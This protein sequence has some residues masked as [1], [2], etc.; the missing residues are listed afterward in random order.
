MDD[1]N[2]NLP[3]EQSTSQPVESNDS[4]QD[5]ATN[6]SFEPNSVSYES[7]ET[8][9]PYSEGLDSMPAEDLTSYDATD[10]TSD[11]ETD[12]TTTPE[13]VVEEQPMYDDAAPEEV[14]Y[15]STDLPDTSMEDLS[16]DPIEVPMESAAP[17]DEVSGPEAY[18]GGD[19]TNPDDILTE[20]GLQDDQGVPASTLAASDGSAL[21][22]PANGGSGNNKKIFALLALTILL[23]GVLAVTVWYFFLRDNG[24]SGPSATPTPTSIPQPT[25]A[26]DTHLECRFGLCVEVPGPGDNLC[27][28]SFDCE[29]ATITPSV[30]P[31]SNPTTIPVASGTPAE[32]SPTP[33]AIATATPEPTTALPTVVP[34]VAPTST[35]TP[36][37][38]S[39]PTPTPLAD[40]LP[41]SGTSDNTLM[42]AFLLAA[43]T[44][45][46]FLL[47][48]KKHV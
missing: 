24:T 40:S 16:T 19:S 43:S 8:T 10:A 26:S 1:Q 41:T 7:T 13:D 38:I 46:G 34:T 15:E 18:E 22:A 2:S 6:D 12:M 29:Q 4:G 27:A 25:T 37:T 32:A 23:L 11:M 47:L 5:T 45:S 48:R 17:V 21:V 42:L 14:S 35:P 28:S 30:G 9:Q 44:A 36:T 33:P 20:F 3:D 31:T 39:T